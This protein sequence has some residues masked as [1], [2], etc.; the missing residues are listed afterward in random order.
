MSSGH[1]L[2]DDAEIKSL[3]WLIDNSE[4]CERI[5]WVNF[6][7]QNFRTY[8]SRNR[9]NNTLHFWYKTLVE[10]VC[11]QFFV[12]NFGNCSISWPKTNFNVA[13]FLRLQFSINAFSMCNLRFSK[14]FSK[15]IWVTFSYSD[16]SIDVFDFL[17]FRSAFLFFRFN[18]KSSSSKNGHWCLVNVFFWVV[19][20]NPKYSPQTLDTYPMLHQYLRQHLTLS[21]T[22][23]DY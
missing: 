17:Y 16:F 22:S 7:F 4:L 12:F 23:I 5:H 18:L 14:N 15:F 3:N 21:T 1:V 10:V 19:E 2:F 8:R 13:N 6:S 11:M 20:R 9:C